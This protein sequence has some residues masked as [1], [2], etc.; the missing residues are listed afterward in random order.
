MA[1]ILVG[2]IRNQLHRTCWSFTVYVVAVALG[3]SLTVGWPAT[4]YNW[5]FWQTKELVYAI[6][7][8]MV[9]LEI[10]ALSFQAFSGARARARQLLVIILIGTLAA[11]LLTPLAVPPP[12]P[13]SLA[14][15]YVE[16]QPRLA[17][18]TVMLF[19]AV[20]GLV[21]W[22]VIPLHRWHRAILR[23]LL[24]YLLVFTIVIRLLASWGWHMRQ[25]V[26]YTDT[27]A[28]MI[29]CLYWA[30]EAWRKESP[31]DPSDIQRRLQPWLDQ[32]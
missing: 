15:L 32:R 6:I 19:G 31:Q 8:F 4:F 7:K 10:A 18:G 29:V 26:G 11:I 23:G 2:M 22:Y 5:V 9:A 1:I 13:V 21:L 14:D 16:I 25:W 28:Y 30:W 3:N 20:W 24:P 17:H 12:G 27:V